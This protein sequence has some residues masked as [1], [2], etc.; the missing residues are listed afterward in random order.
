[1]QISLRTGKLVNQSGLIVL[2]III[3]GLILTACGD[4]TTPPTS[5][6]TSGSTTTHAA[7][8][9]TNVTNATTNNSATSLTTIAAS[10]TAS[11]KGTLN[12]GVSRDLV[13]GQKDPY[14][15]HNSLNVWESLTYL[16]NDLNPQPMLA[17]SWQQAPD[18]LSWTFQIR[19]NVKFTDGTSLNAKVVVFNIERFLKIAPR[20]SPFF[21]LEKGMKVAYGDLKNVEA[22][23]EYSVRFNLNAPAPGLPLMLANFFSMVQAPAAFTEQLEFKSLPVTT[24]PYKLVDWKKGQYAL[25]EANENYWGTPP[26]IKTIRVRVLPDANARVA[27]LKAGEVDALTELGSVLPEQAA[28]LK[29][30]P[31]FEVQGQLAALTHYLTFNGSKAPFNDVRLRQAVNFALDRESV[32]KNILYGYGK[33]GGPFLTSVLGS[34]SDGTI[35]F[36]YNLDKAKELFKQAGAQPNTPILLL[37]SSAQVNQY[38]Y[39]PIAELMQSQLAKVGFTLE[40]KVIDSGV[41]TPALANGDYNLYLSTQGLANGDPDYL[42]SRY[43]TSKATQ[44]TSR[45]MGYSNPKIDELTDQ[46]AKEL[47]LGKRKEQYRQIQQIVAQEVPIVPLYYTVIVTASRKIVK[48]LTMDATYK[49]TLAKASLER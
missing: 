3:A 28:D 30:D 21:S 18:G 6:P 26:N 5:N 24:G 35:K 15:T 40:I 46:A 12:L 1:M 49:P 47:N 48:G 2:L 20:Q 43:L 31:Q 4:P 27:A 42:V 34:W 41:L 44:N 25:L 37:I 45:K 10:L 7:V 19:K 23:D 38:P 33:A 29:K 39:K 8:T 11:P 13:E 14:F 22:L 9:T 16:D 36:D 32:V 17:E